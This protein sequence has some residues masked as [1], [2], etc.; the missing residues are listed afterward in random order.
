MPPY[1]WHSQR[2]GTQ[3]P[4]ILLLHGTG[5]STHSWAPVMSLLED[6]AQICAVDLPGHGYSD[7]PSIG[8]STLANCTHGINLLMKCLDFNPDL[9]V[10]HS[11][12]A[13]IAVSLAPK[14]GPHTRV[15]CVN[16][17]FSQFAGIAGIMFPYIAKFA[18]TAP[19]S[20][21]LLSLAAQ[22]TSRVKRLLDGT[23]SNLPEESLRAYLSLFQSEK[24]VR[25]TLHFMA[26]WNLSNFLETLGQTQTSITF[27]T[28]QNDKTVNPEI[29]RHWANKIKGA[30]MIEIPQFG[31]LIQE[32]APT[33]VAERI[34][35]AALEPI[36]R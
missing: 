8:W 20:A 15:M 14:F 1:H 13:A 5:T 28:A 22:D 35:A 6:Q 34:L 26:Q 7:T 17:A 36:V 10:G 33:L 24:H 4:K 9:I 11:A 32:E 16:A 18:A 23:G 21:R 27:L 30:E 12:A 3:G 31:H 29:S 19:F 25:G 2:V